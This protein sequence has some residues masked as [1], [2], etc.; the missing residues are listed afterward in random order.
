MPPTTRAS[1]PERKQ[2]WMRI[3]TEVLEEEEDGALNSSL[4]RD[5]YETLDDISTMDDA[6]IMAL[7]YEH[8]L[9]SY[10]KKEA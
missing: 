9:L 2:E 8:V 7:K 5:G 4:K 1:L 6:E 3:L 10:N